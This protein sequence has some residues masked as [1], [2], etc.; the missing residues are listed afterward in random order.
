MNEFELPNRKRK[1][2][3]LLDDQQLVFNMLFCLSDGF[4]IVLS[5]E[6]ITK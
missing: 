1:L 3:F 5:N 2:T 6:V 4:K